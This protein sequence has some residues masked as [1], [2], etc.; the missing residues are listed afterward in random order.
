MGK[1]GRF[2]TANSCGG[3]DLAFDATKNGLRSTLTGTEYWYISL[4]EIQD[5]VHDQQQSAALALRSTHGSWEGYGYIP[6]TAVGTD[7]QQPNLDGWEWDKQRE[8]GKL[9]R[10]RPSP[11]RNGYL[12]THLCFFFPPMVSSGCLSMSCC[13]W[14]VSD[15]WCTCLQHSGR[16]WLAVAG[17]CSRGQHAHESGTFSW[18]REGSTVWHTTRVAPHLLSLRARAHTHT[19]TNPAGRLSDHAGEAGTAP[20]CDSS[21]VQHGIQHWEK[22]SNSRL[23]QIALHDPGQSLHAATRRPFFFISS[24]VARAR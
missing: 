22:E 17:G 20:R 6:Q 5:S 3:A 4:S 21:L 14:A 19:H 13:R 1:K 8:Q 2:L 15:H 23:N 24:F 18:G 7:R 16:S 11:S 12:F 10:S 9:P